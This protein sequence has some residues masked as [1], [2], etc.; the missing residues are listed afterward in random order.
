MGE[1][2]AVARQVA[3][4][5]SVAANAALPLEYRLEAFKDI[6]DSEVG[7]TSLVRARNIEREGL[8][9]LPASTAGLLA[10]LDHQG[11]QPLPGDRYV[12]VL[13]GRRS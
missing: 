2:E 4:Q 6:I 11:Q 7:D 5:R 1:V 13:P 12:A 3:Q 8:Q 10:L 9:V